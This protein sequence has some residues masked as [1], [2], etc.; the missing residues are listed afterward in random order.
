MMK[1]MLAMTSNGC[2]NVNGD[3][4]NEVVK[5]E[6]EKKVEH[7]GCGGDEMMIDDVDEYGDNF[8]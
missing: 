5:E 4:E 6:E 2:K 3:D 1:T 8:V 7:S